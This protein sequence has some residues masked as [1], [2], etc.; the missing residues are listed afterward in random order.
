MFAQL[1]RD[2][3]GDPS[4]STATGTATYLGAALWTSSEPYKKVSMKDI[5][6]GFERKCDRRLGSLAAALLRDRLDSGQGRKQRRPDPQGQPGNYIIGYT[7]PALT[8]ALVA[9]SKPAP[10]CTPARKA[11]PS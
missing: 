2:A 10:C 9:R 8:V 1:K 5:D 11:R 4:S 3:S 7:G 6:K